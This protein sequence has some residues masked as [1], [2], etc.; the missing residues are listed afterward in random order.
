MGELR[1]ML[2]LPVRVTRVS[3]KT[4]QK[5]PQNPGQSTLKKRGVLDT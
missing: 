2:D 4:R 5:Y 3:P 1:R